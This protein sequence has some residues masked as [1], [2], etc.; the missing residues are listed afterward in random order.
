[1][2]I[3]NGSNSTKSLTIKV[4]AM[5]IKGILNDK[6]EDINNYWYNP[7]SGVVYDFDLY[8]PIGKIKYDL[9]GIPVKVDKDTYH[10]ELIHIP[11]IK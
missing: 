3:E 8:F 1:M 5:K 2:K 11:L 10:I 6:K 9:D 7:D 4:K